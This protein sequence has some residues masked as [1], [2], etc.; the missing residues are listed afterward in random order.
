MGLLKTEKK[1][2]LGLPRPLGITPLAGLSE[3][4]AETPDEFI[5]SPL[6]QE[7]PPAMGTY[8]YRGQTPESYCIECLVRH[9]SKV[10][11]LM[12]EGERFSLK[13]GKLVPEAR[14]RVRAA[15]EEMVTAEEDLG[16]EIKDEKLKKIIDEIDVK[17]RDLRKYI[18]AERLTTSQEDIESLGGA[19]DRARELVDLTYRAAM[20]AE[21][22]HCGKKSVE[23]ICK[24]LPEEK[25]V[26][27]TEALKVVMEGREEEF[28]KILEKEV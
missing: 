23:D 4:P 13:S 20:I 24:D 7:T 22:P 28:K 19:I 3:K 10:H 12:K 5:P 9:Y 11:G 27:C 8:S 1:G 21:C 18:W 6:S 25:R 26:K 15:V 17:Q 16:T 2:L 14:Q